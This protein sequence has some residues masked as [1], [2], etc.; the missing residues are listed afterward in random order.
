MWSDAQNIML[1]SVQTLDRK[2]SSLNYLDVNPSTHA[3]RLAFGYQ[4][5]EASQYSKAP[6][7]KILHRPQPDLGPYKTL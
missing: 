2:K 6:C 1:Q 5:R 4:Y 7:L 3:I